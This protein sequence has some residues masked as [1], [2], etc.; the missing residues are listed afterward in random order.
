MQ[1]FKKLART[2]CKEIKRSKAD[3][4]YIE[5]YLKEGRRNAITCQRLANMLNVDRRVISKWIE[6]ARRRNV[7]ICAIMT[8][9]EPGYYIAETKRDVIEYAESLKGRAIE[10]FKTRKALLQACEGLPDALEDPKGVDDAQL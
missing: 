3:M 9:S 10:I 6:Q 5:E 8:G 2:A 7:P 4:K 1:D